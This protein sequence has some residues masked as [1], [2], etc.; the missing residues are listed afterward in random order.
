MLSN[1][2]LGY[3]LLQCPLLKMERASVDFSGFW[4]RLG[5]TLYFLQAFLVWMKG[6]LCAGFFFPP[7]L[8]F[9]RCKIASESSYC[10]NNW[11]QQCPLLRARGAEPGGR[12]A[13]GR[14]AWGCGARGS[15]PGLRS[16]DA[17]AQAG[18]GSGPSGLSCARAAGASL[19]WCHR[20]PS[21][22]GSRGCSRGRLRGCCRHTLFSAGSPSR[23]FLVL[24]INI[25]ATAFSARLEARRQLR[26]WCLV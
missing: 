12:G 15:E 23:A 20:H 17:A 19:A 7:F 16:R 25:G 26:N 18:H 2:V 22:A 9:L 21:A 1:R 3:S 6:S 10:R 14:G 5:N 8:R 4:I 11:L 24:G 13:W